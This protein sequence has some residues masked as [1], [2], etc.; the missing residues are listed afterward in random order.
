ML[1]LAVA[2]AP[3]AM[4]AQH[5]SEPAPDSAPDQAAPTMFPHSDTTRY[6]L[7]GQANIIFQSHAP[8]HSLYEGTNSFLS[9][10][11]Y[12]TSIIGTLYSA[13]EL[14][15]NRKYA[16]DLILDVEAA[17]GR[18]LSEALG[19]AGFTNLDVVRNP[20]LGSTPY[21]A[22]Y[23]VHQVIGLSDDMSESSRTS[24]SLQPALPVRRIELWV[25][26]MS[27]PD[28][29]DQNAV[30]TDSHLQFMNWSI[31]NMGSWDYAANTRGYT[32]AVVAEYT[33]Q[34]FTGRFAL[35]AMPSVANGIDLVYNLHKAG[36]YNGELEL[37]NGP[38]TRLQII[39]GRKGAVR[40]LAFAN[41]ANMGD[42]REQINLFLSKHQAAVPDI[43]DHPQQVTTKYGFGADFEQEV[44]N[45][46]RIWG[47]FGWNEGQHESYAYTEIDQTIALGGD[48][49]LARFH[50][51]NDKLGLT[52]VSNA[53]KKDHQNYLKLGGLGF[54]LGDGNLNYGREQIVE[55]Y[56]NRHV[57]KG[58]YYAFDEQFVAHPGYNRDRGPVMVESV[59]TH[60]DF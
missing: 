57:W 41:R 9:R 14:N 17:G 29:L 18:G 42:Y 31:D 52:Y 26:R 58:I 2:C 59:R 49:S 27:L 55:A 8:F 48:Y 28:L 51:L 11:E 12:K 53:I 10:G 33:D 50:R 34:N 23:E 1:L 20:S 16:T 39:P 40:A 6:L 54:L 3:V 22:R 13:Y 38:G 4:L 21:L 43:T 36:G 24:F 46:G 35:A 60:I 47:Q 37:R 15:P 32:D 30:G 5:P 44:S 45:N 56:Y 19:I 25:G 7:G